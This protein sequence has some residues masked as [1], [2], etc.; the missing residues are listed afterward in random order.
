MVNM[1]GGKKNWTTE[2]F[3]SEVESIFLPATADG[4][5]AKP[6]A[7]TY[8]AELRKTNRRDNSGNG[9]RNGGAVKDKSICN[10]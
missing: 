1:C 4:Q 7:E 6:S 10:G 5:I 8:A 9:S 2:S 3:G